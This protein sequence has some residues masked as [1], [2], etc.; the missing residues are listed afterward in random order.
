MKITQFSPV[1]KRLS[2]T[3]PPKEKKST[4]GMTLPPDNRH[5]W[6]GQKASRI[7]KVRDLAPPLLFRFK[8]HGFENIPQD[9]NF[10]AGPTHQGYMDAPVATR[11]VD[12]GRPFAS[13]ADV[14]QFRGPLGRMLA[15]IGSFPVD[16]YGEYAGNFPD[17]VSH[18]QEILNDGKN[19][20]MYPEGR[21]GENGHVYPI[22]NGIAR[23]SLGSNAK[24]A[25]P[26]L[27]HFEAD[28]QAHPLETIVGVP[29]EGCHLSE[30]AGAI[31][32]MGT[33]PVA[34]DPLSWGSCYSHPGHPRIWLDS[35]ID[36][37]RRGVFLGVPRRT[38]AVYQRRYDLKPPG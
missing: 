12:N 26:M 22:K 5:H 21:F 17:P 3:Q 8:D 1:D 24:Y 14:N 19:F 18:T 38:V 10:I 16:R 11:V 9:A 32:G 31:G 28:K 4:E 7:R 13:M 15:D 27:Q 29:R 35:Q 37:Q 36:G 6:D 2:G 23:I 34:K 30:K 20:V 33:S 25:V